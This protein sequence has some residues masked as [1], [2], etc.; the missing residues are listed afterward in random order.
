MPPHDWCYPVT[1]EEHPIALHQLSGSCKCQPENQKSGYH[2]QVRL[3][4]VTFIV[5]CT[6]LLYTMNNSDSVLLQC[7]LWCRF[8]IPCNHHHI[9]SDER[10]TDPSRIPRAISRADPGIEPGTLNSYHVTRPF[11]SRIM[12]KTVEPR[13][14]AT[15]QNKYS[16]EYSSE[17]RMVQILY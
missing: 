8:P 13:S 14:E 15:K 12:Q 10:S 1:Q 17:Y 7:N 9:S 3:S 4:D 2:Q 11:V 6:V 5:E 16:R